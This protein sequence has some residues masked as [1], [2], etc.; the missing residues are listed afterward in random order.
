MSALLLLIG[1][2]LQSALSSASPACDEEGNDT[3]NFVRLSSFAHTSNSEFIQ[4][5][6]ENRKDWRPRVPPAIISDSGRLQTIDLSNGDERFFTYV[7]I[8]GWNNQ[9]LNLLCA[10]DMARLIN[11]TLVIPP[12]SWP[13]RRG[14]AKV[15]VCRLIDVTSL[16][17]AG[18]RAICEDEHG[19]IMEALAHEPPLDGHSG[20]ADIQGEG[21]PHRKRRMPRWSRKWWIDTGAAAKSR[22]LRVSCCLFWTWSLPSDVALGLYR[23]VQYHPALVRAA[24][25]AAA[26]LGAESFAAMHVR[27]GDKA[28]VDVAYTGIFGARMTADYFVSLARDEGFASA[29]TI[30][31]AT[32]ELD[33]VDWFD[34]LRDA[35]YTLRFVDD[36][37]QRP[38]LDALSTFPQAV[39]AD[40]LAI[41]EQLVCIEAPGGFVGS[42]PSTLS[43][44]I[45]NVRQARSMA[46]T[47]AKPLFTKV[48][49]SCCDARTALDLLMLPGVTSLA[50]VP[51]EPHEGNPW[52]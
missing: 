21:Q 39:W 36:L 6:A 44:H 51:C 27:Q 28:T 11:R 49:E 41:L 30:F 33:Q 50:D 40:I 2:I 35:G 5:V 17:E 31:V 22:V 10:I 19:S 48:H 29:A 7:S 47:A 37:A 18:V 1:S 9:L 32:D 23:T 26:P 20:V 52:C 3:A 8:N 38:L 12:F 13:R 15:S 4:S 42:L 45:I 16:A 46:G 43:G 34:P 25:D 24:R 14:Q